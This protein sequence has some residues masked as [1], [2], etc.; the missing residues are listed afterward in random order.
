[1]TAKRLDAIFDRRLRQIAAWE[2]E[3]MVRDLLEVL[4]ARAKRPQGPSRSGSTW[5]EPCAFAGGP[6]CT[7]AW[8]AAAANLRRDVA[9]E[10]LGELERRGVVRSTLSAD[11][12]EMLWALGDAA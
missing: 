9:L 1:M 10:R 8:L 6:L 11:G 7:T 4:K 5:P 12:A 2:R 3:Q